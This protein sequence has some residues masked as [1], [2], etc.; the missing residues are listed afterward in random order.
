MNGRA[1]ATFRRGEASI[2]SQ[3]AGIVKKGNVWN[4]SEDFGGSQFANSWDGGKELRLVAQSRIL[5]QKTIGLVLEVKELLR[6]KLKLGGMQGPHKGSQVFVLRTIF[7]LNDLGLQGIIMAAEVTQSLD[8]RAWRLPL[9][10]M[11]CLAKR[12]YQ[13]RICSIGFGSFELTLG[14][15]FDA[16]RVDDTDKMTGFVQMSCKR[17]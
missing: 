12:S 15:G 9:G 5:I 14:I 17:Q 7:D 16:R 1:R 2:G 8:F 4:F 13:E 6:E 3:L 11:L 10:R